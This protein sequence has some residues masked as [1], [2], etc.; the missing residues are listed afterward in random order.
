M[1]KF[2][3]NCG[4]F[5]VSLEKKEKMEKFNVLNWD[6]NKD[7]LE[8]YNIIPY[9]I[10]RYDEKVKKFKKIKKRKSYKDNPEKYEKDNYYKVP[11][12]IEEL[13][14]FI[15]DES[16]YQFWSRCEYEMIVHGWPVR[17]NEHKLD[18]HEQIMMNIDI[19]TKIVWE[20]I[21]KEIKKKKE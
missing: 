13:K 14:Q 9:F 4:I 2:L 8:Y 15:K 11:K 17:K 1:N 20:E 5:F 18:I 7:K 3:L 16:Q 10:R 6:F 21:N 19:V 12:T